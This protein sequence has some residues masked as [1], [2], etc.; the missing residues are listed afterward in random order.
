MFDYDERSRGVQFSLLIHKLSSYFRDRAALP[1]SRLTVMGNTALVSMSTQTTT[2]SA[3]VEK[4]KPKET[5]LPITP[6]QFKEYNQ[7]AVRMDYYVHVHA[8]LHLLIL[9]SSNTTR[10]ATPGGTA[11]QDR[12]LQSRTSLSSFLHMALHFCNHLKSCYDLEEPYCSPCLR[13]KGGASRRKWTCPTSTCRF[14]GV[15]WS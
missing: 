8:T 3:L 11:C 1:F 13:A 14:T 5:L 9:T 10:S 4:S 12:A 7:L 6:W 15:C 2:S